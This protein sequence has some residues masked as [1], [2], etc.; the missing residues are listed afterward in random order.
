MV[1]GLYLIH[2]RP[3]IIQYFFYRI[4]LVD[5]RVGDS[6]R[7]KRRTGRCVI[8]VADR[9][10]I[11]PEPDHIGLCPEIIHLPGISPY[12]RIPVSHVVKGFRYLPHRIFHPVKVVVCDVC[13]FCHLVYVCLDPV[14]Y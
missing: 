14:K 11:I 8:C 9:L 12:N 2:K 13:L 10:D 5:G 1:S 6:V 7:R 3:Q 4:R